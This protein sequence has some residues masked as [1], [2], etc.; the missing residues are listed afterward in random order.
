MR[1]SMPKLGERAQQSGFVEVIQGSLSLARALP[2]PADGQAVAAR[3]RHRQPHQGQRLCSTRGLP[4]AL[5]RPG[6]SRERAHRPA[7]V[8]AYRAQRGLL[9]SRR[10][11]RGAS[12]RV[13]CVHAPGLLNRSTDTYVWGGRTGLSAAGPAHELRPHRAIAGGRSRGGALPLQGGLESALRRRELD[14]CARG[15]LAFF[16][17]NGGTVQ[18]IDLRTFTPL[19]AFAA[20]DDTD[21]SLALDT[22]HFLAPRSSPAAKSTRRGRRASP[23]CAASTR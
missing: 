8:R 1:H 16:A 21:A 12:A 4:L 13:G 3:H 23:T 15:R 19:W 10:R 14:V 2:R 20:G 11:Q 22:P 9:S 6:Y 5:R 17:D 7:R 18:A